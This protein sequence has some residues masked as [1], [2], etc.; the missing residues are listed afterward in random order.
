MRR[1]LGKKNPLGARAV[2]KAPHGALAAISQLYGDV[3]FERERKQALIALCAHSPAAQQDPDIRGD[4]QARKSRHGVGGP[5]SMDLR[6]V[7]HVHVDAIYR[8]GLLHP[9]LPYLFKALG[10][11]RPP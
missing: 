8:T 10:S 4:S 9:L 7:Q 1:N 6:H 3:G 5:A 2:P 11:R